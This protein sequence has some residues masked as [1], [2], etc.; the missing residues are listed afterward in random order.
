MKETFEQGWSARPFKEQF[1]ELGEAEAKRLDEVNHAISRLYVEDMITESQK[2]TIRNKKCP[3]MVSTFVM[4][5]RRKNT[6]AGK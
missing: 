3:K 6:G 1:P 5:A 2:D 4:D